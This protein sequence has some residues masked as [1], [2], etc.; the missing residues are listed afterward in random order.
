M[1]YLEKAPLDQITLKDTAECVHM[2]PSYLSQLFKQQLNKKFVDYITELR[3]EESKRLLLNTSL[4]MSEIAERVG[5]SDLAY[6]SNNFK[7]ITGCSPSEFR[8]SAI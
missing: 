6:F 2:N 5:Y 8:K 3:I 1:Q 4:R 7:R